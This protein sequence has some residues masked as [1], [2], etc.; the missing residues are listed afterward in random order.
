MR[1]LRLGGDLA[2]AATDAYE[3][4]VFSYPSE[5]QV[6]QNEGDKGETQSKLDTK[7]RIKNGFELPC[8]YRK[9]NDITYGEKHA[10]YT[11]THL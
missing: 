3:D 1:G 10:E 4:L 7:V 2:D 5:G 6:E 11:H 9:I 8:S